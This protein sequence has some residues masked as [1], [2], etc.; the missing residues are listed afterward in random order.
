MIRGF[1]FELK[2]LSESGVFE[3]LAS[4][5]DGEPDLVG[6]IIRPG[7]FVRT[8]SKSATRPLLMAHSVPIGTVSLKD[9]T[10]GL[11]ASGKLSL[12]VQAAKDAYTL[13]KD[14]AIQG[15][16]IGF[17]TV[18]DE[19]KDGIRY[20]TEIKLFEISLCAV[21]AN[22]QALVTS[23]KSVNNDEVRR[24]LASFR[25]EIVRAIGEKHRGN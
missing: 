17:Q 2:Q 25:S 6:D 13:L 23:V 18:E 14:G 15:L 3:G 11:T 8:L 20:L 12:G 9:S 7:A 19:V 24:A 5:Y 4:T 21:P 16:S 22:Q 1:D 10:K